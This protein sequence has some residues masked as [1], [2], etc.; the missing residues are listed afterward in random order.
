MD[1][2]ALDRTFQLVSGFRS[3]QMVVAVTQLKIPDLVAAGPQSA[4]E[5]AAATG[6]Q[7]DPLRRVL[8]C[9]VTVGVFTET[10]DGRFAATPVSECLRDQPGSMRGQALMLPMESYAAYGD[11][12]HC[13][14]TGESAFEHVFGVTHWEKLALDPERSSIF[15]AAMQSGTERIQAAVVAACDF[16]GLRSFI[17]VGGGRGTLTAALLKSNPHLRAAVFDLPSGLAETEALLKAQGVDDR[18]ELVSGNFFESVPSGH[19]VYLLKQIV[20][21]WNDEKATEILVTC[22]KAMG[23]GS[24]VILV[25]RNLPARAEESAAARAIFMTDIQMLVMFGSRER[26]EAEYGALMHQAGLRLTRVIPTDS[27]F[28]LIEGVPA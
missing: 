18:C 24:R 17:D 9:L 21:D 1:S 10:T 6:V 27:I 5:L 7:A 15:N 12:L 19:D 22:R 26:T 14:R 25:E 11:L 28:H 16:Q 3:T 8:Q 2:A 23:P 20:H 4:D 13:L